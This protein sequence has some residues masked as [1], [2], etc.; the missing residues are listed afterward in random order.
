MH[1]PGAWAAARYP[2][3]G[4]PRGARERTGAARADVRAVLEHARTVGAVAVNRA[5]G[6]WSA[7]WMAD[8]RRDL[9]RA[10]IDLIQL[11]PLSGS[12]NAADIRLA[13]DVVDDVHHR[14]D[15]TDVIVVGGDSDY[16][17][18][19]Q[20]CHREGQ[21]FH[22]VGV[23]GSTASALTA[24]CDEFTFYDVLR[25]T[26]RPASGPDTAAPTTE[27]ALLVRALTR[28]GH[29]LPDGWAVR[30]RIQEA[31]TGLDPTFDLRARGH[32]N[33]TALLDAHASVVEGRGDGPGRR[34]RLRDG[35]PCANP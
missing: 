5:Y 1:G 27:R 10:A 2:R 3:P 4:P 24:A 26:D 18:L 17:P 8:Y 31:M 33:L 32:R 23:R 30:P 9:Q 25:P 28:L 11:F 34:Y 21:R 29:D 20:H 14:S 16:V 22:G 13:I 12:K 15:L 7:W 6:D 19:A 35:A